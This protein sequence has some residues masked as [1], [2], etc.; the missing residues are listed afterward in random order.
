MRLQSTRG[1]QMR[2]WQ[3]QCVVKVGSSAGGVVAMQCGC[4]WATPGA[5]PWGPLRMHLQCAVHAR[6]IQSRV[7]HVHNCPKAVGPWVGCIAPTVVHTQLLAAATIA[8][9]ANANATTDAL[10]AT[11]TA[12]VAA[13]PL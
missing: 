5:T 9:A 2:Q 4:P 8:V 1:V 10:A 11:L 6:P 13:A 7:W 12:A 3:R